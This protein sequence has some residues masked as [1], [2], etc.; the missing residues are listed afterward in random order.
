MKKEETCSNCRFQ[1]YSRCM[2]HAPI[3]YAKTYDKG[4]DSEYV[5]M[6]QE[7]PYIPY[8]N[9]CGDWEKAI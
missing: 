1:E 9:W 7:F 2:R 4:M 8:S 3:G 6:E 5:V